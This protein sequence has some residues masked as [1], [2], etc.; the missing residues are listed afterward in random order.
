M[1]LSGVFPAMVTPFHTDGTLHVEMLEILIGR[2]YEGGADGLYIC[3]Q[4]GEGMQ[5]PMAQ[6][7][8]VAEHSVR[9][10][11]VGK[12]VIVHVGAN[13]T[14]EAMELARHAESV[15]AHLISSLP[16]MG[17]Y[18]FEEI[19]KYYRDL[20]AATSLPLLLYHHPESCP[21][22]TPDR[23]LQLCDLPNVE[24]FKFTDFN[25]YLLT[26]ICDRGLKVFNGKDEIFAGGLLLGAS[27][28][29]GTFYNIFPGAFVRL[30]ALSQCGQWDQ[31]ANLQRAMNRVIEELFKMPMVPGVREV[32]RLR[33]LE[34]GDSL[35]P[36]RPLTICEKEQVAKI[37]VNLPADIAPFLISAE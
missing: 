1:H 37:L 30:F 24:G 31:A 19:V 6:R 35:A 16:P 5:Q 25:L 32:L 22:L 4:T 17:L 3:G 26:L 2:L 23:A 18:A 10:S 7:K 13:S 27:G 36:R 29:I 21:Q 11:P 12:S 34:C 15:G 9:L 20:A 28:G 33:G 14:R 8:A